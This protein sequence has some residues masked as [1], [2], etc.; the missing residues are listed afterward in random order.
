MTEEETKIVDLI[1]YHQ[2]LRSEF[3][4]Q[5]AY[6][7]MYQGNLGIEHI[8]GDTAAARNYLEYEMSAVQESEFPDEPLIENI[9]TDTS[10]VRINLRSFKRLG[11]NTEKLWR[12]M[13]AS[14]ESYPKVDEKFIHAWKM[15]VSLCK[16]EA[17]SFNYETVK[18]FDEQMKSNNYPSAHHSKVYMDTYKP[19]YRV[20]LLKEFENMF[21]LPYH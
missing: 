19:A 7:L 13:V 10:I 17:L 9:S 8:M 1:H 5:D 14:A 11:M 16:T 15:L 4:I 12:T 2:N 21:Q 20:V 6:K 3:E 18:L